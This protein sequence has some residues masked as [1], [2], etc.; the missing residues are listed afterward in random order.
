MKKLIKT[1]LVIAAT[2]LTGNAQAPAVGVTAEMTP[3]QQQKV[4]IA[5]Q[6]VGVK[7]ASLLTGDLGALKA[8]GAPAKAEFDY[9]LTDCMLIQNR[10]MLKI[11]PDKVV[12]IEVSGDQAVETPVELSADRLHELNWNITKVKREF[13]KFVQSAFNKKYG[14]KEVTFIGEDTT[15]EPVFTFKYLPISMSASSNKVMGKWFGGTVVA[16]KIIVTETASGKE[17]A[18]LVFND[19]G[20]YQTGLGGGEQAAIEESAGWA[21]QNL[22]ESLGKLIKKGK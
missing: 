2:A 4:E 18:T 14:K 3:E 16:G 19:M 5:Q 20:S 21:G 6:I 15:A 1:I 7:G 13:E 9:S 11:Y 22:A 12:K 10:E 17:I 8:N